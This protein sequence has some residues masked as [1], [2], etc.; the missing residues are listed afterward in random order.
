M[1]LTFSALAMIY[2]GMDME[3]VSLDPRPEKQI[4]PWFQIM[5]MADANQALLYID[6]GKSGYRLVLVNEKHT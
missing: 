3:E 2:E 1:A 4:K 5:S 6:D